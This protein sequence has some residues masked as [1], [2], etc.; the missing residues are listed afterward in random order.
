MS[1]GQL[2]ENFILASMRVY[3]NSIFI[4]KLFVETSYTTLNEKLSEFTSSFN[5]ILIKS[6]IFL[7]ESIVIEAEN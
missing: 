5:Y 3:K 1:S 7:P 6:S 2:K 4:K